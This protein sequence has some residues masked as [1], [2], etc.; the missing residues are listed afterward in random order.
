MAQIVA[1]VFSAHRDYARSIIAEGFG[2]ASDYP[3]GPFLSDRLTYKGEELVEFT[4]PAHRK[5][6]GTISWLLPS[7]QQSPA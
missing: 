1:I 3:F 5:G 6:L 7:E 2:P 4:T